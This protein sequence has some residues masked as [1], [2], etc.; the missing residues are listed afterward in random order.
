MGDFSPPLF[1]RSFVRKGK[2]D[3][4]QNKTE[5]KPKPVG[6]QASAPGAFDAS[7]LEEKL[8]LKALVEE[9]GG[10]NPKR[11]ATPHTHTHTQPWAVQNLHPAASGELE[12]AVSSLPGWGTPTPYS[13]GSH[14]WVADSSS[15]A[16]VSPPSFPSPNILFP[17]SPQ[18]N[19]SPER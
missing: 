4:K 6:F 2:T 12:V 7:Q 5:A 9:G 14:P 19:D 18:F 3:L 11:K 15:G 13:Q 16:R 8:S 10:G 1:L 17:P